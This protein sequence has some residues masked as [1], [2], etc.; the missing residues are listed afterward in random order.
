[1][2]QQRPAPVTVPHRPTRVDAAR[3]FDRLV[4]TADIVFS[5]QGADASLDEIAKRAGVGSGTLYRH[6]PNREALMT[7][8]YWGR[9]EELCAEGEKLRDAPEPDHAL[10]TWLGMLIDLTSKRALAMALMTHQREQASE[11]F[12]ACRQ[13]LDAAASPLL[14]RAQ[15]AGMMRPDLSVGD[16]LT[17]SHAIAAAVERMPDGPDH[18]ARLL[19]LLIEGLRTRTEP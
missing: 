14:A 12:R 5:E 18:G 7:A 15:V 10:I 11:L 1:M 4:V 3:N 17:F 6:F 9:I 19:D 16:L 13:A 2:S 8:V